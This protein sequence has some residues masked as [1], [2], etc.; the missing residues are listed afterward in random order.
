MTTKREADLFRYL[1]QEVDDV[2]SS[3]T[4][5]AK[6]PTCGTREYA[7]SALHVT[8]WV[9]GAQ[10]V[11]RATYE[12]FCIG[13]YDEVVLEANAEI[14]ELLSSA[15]VTVT[16]NLVPKEVLEHPGADVA[17]LDPQDLLNFII[18]LGD[19]LDQRLGWPE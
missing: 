7:P 8:A 15:G 9:G 1:E 2:A 19:A 10:C 5:K 12:F 18:D 13:C 4:I 3:C 11:V 17:P 14:V 16:T 6:C